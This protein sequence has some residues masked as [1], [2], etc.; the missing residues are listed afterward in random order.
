MTDER[1]GHEEVHDSGF[2]RVWLDAVAD[3]TCETEEYMRGLA[4]LYNLDTEEP[5]EVDCAAIRQRLWHTL[6]ATSYIGTQ[7]WWEH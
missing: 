2:W 6:K 1:F 3:T 7:G 4:T 5:E